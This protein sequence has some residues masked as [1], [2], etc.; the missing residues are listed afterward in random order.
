MFS[1]TYPYIKIYKLI[2]IFSKEGNTLKIFSFGILSAFRCH[3]SRTKFFFRPCDYAASIG[4]KTAAVMK[5]LRQNTHS[6]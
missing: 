1:F 2:Q 3:Q 6:V 5:F 4:P